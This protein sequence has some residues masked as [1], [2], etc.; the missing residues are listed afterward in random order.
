VFWV[1]AYREDGERIG[2]RTARGRA[3]AIVAAVTLLERGVEVISVTDEDESRSVSADE[4]RRVRELRHTA[5]LAS[6]GAA[7]AH[8]RG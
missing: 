5:P 1:V 8:S 3:A 2:R 4:M 6:L 7:R